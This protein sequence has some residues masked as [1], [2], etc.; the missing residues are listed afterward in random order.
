MSPCLGLLRGEDVGKS[1]KGLVN[2][3]LSSSE[4]CTD[5]QGCF[6]ALWYEIMYK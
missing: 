2:Y 4:D 3:F 1:A 5:P 6:L